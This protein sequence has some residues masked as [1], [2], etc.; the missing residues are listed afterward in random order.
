MLRKC[1][2]FK[3]Y[4]FAICNLTYISFM[5]PIIFMNVIILVIKFALI[6]EEKSYLS[7]LRQY[8][9]KNCCT[10]RGG[11]GVPTPSHTAFVNIKPKFVYLIQR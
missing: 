4:Y 10:H 8:T 1:L 11:R 3:T 5:V 2:I 9:H 6:H 7:Q